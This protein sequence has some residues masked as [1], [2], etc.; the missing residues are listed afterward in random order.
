MDASYLIEPVPDLW[1]LMIDANVFE[2][3]N[4]DISKSDSAAFI[5]S[6]DAGWNAMLIHKPFIL[7]WMKDVSKRAELKGKTLLAFSHYPMIDMM[8]G[9]TADEQ[10]LLGMT[11][12]V[13]RTPLNKVASAVIDSGVS[14]HFSGHLHVNDTACF[15]NATGTLTNIGVPS[16]VAFPPA[17]KVLTIHNDKMDIE[18]ISLNNIPIDSEISARYRTEIAVTRKNIGSMLE[19]A[20]YGEFLSKHVDQLVIHRYLKREWPSKLAHAITQLNL[21]DLFLL[22]Y[23]ENELGVEE[24]G[25]AMKAERSRSSR[26]NAS[27][28]KMAS[29]SALDLIGDWYRLRMGSEMALEWISD[30]RLA[31]YR[32]LIDA[33]TSKVTDPGEARQTFATI[34]RMMASYMAGLPS[35]NFSVSLD[36]GQLRSRS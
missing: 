14:V 21:C 33:Y 13:R 20:S 1:L 36:T 22:A 25:P 31:I 5:D 16:L 35:R 15:T 4:G 8:D 12:S 3:R 9:T 34:F 32:L 30:D 18:T 7:E 26:M 17:Y 19:A 27:I 6:T 11:S 24:I 28:E 10:T 2:P 29:V 23:C